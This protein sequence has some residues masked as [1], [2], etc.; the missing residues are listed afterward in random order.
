MSA[1]LNRFTILGNV[2]KAPDIKVSAS[3]VAYGYISIATSK[4]KKVDGKLTETTNWVSVKVLGRI[5]EV[6]KEFVVGGNRIMVEGEIH[7]EKFVTGG[8]EEKWATTL[9]VGQLFLINGKNSSSSPAPTP[10]P[11]DRWGEFDDI[12]F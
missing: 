12:P 9:M 10:I 3:G 11:S 5:A 6:V 4:M 8:G 1:S 2:G 7:N